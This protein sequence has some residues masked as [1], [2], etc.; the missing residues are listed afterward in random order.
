M[1]N[2]KHNT[3]IPKIAYF[4]WN[5][6]TPLSYLRYVTLLTFRK[7]HP[8]WNMT[9]CLSNANT[10]NKWLGLEQQ[11]F[12]FKIDSIDYT[13]KLFELNI[14]FMEYDK[15]T[16]KAPNYISDFFRWDILS[17]TGG[18]YFDLDQIFLKPFD[19][20]C[21]NDFVID[22]SA[23][24][25][26]GVVGC[27]K[28]CPAAK[29]ISDRIMYAYN[30]RFYNSVGPWYIRSLIHTPKDLK[31]FKLLEPYKTLFTE[32][33]I[34]YPIHP[35]NIDDIFK[36][37][38]SLP[39][40]SYTLHWF[41][42]HPVSQEYNKII[43]E[44]S[45]FEQSSTIVKFIEN[46]L[47]KKD[48]KVSFG[49]IVVNGEPWIEIV[50]KGLYKH[51]HS[52]CIAE[53]ATLNW[54]RGNNFKTPRSTDNTLSIIKDF[55]DPENKIRFVSSPEFYAEK[56]EQCNAWLD[57]VPKDTDYIWEV[58]TDEF[59]HDKDI[60]LIKKMLKTN[61]YTYVEFLT[62]NFFKGTDYIAQ[63]GIGWAYDTPFP[64]IFK[65]HNNCKWS[66]HRPPTILD[67]NGRDLKTIKPLLAKDN[68]VK[69]YHYSYVTDKQ[70][71]EK[72]QYYTKAF[73]RD[74]INQW[75]I[76][77]YKNWNNENRLEL[78]SRYSA[79]PS[80]KGATT[81]RF[82]GEHPK[83]IQQNVKLKN[84]SI[85]IRL[86]DFPTGIR[87]IMSDIEPLVEILKRF[88]RH[89]KYIKLGIVPKLLTP[90]YFNMIKDLEF[91]PCIHGYDHHYYEFS[92][93]L[94]NDPYNQHTIV[95][96]FNE[97][98]GD[99]TEKIQA[100]LLKGQTILEQYFQRAITTYIPP[101]NQLDETT[102]KILINL[103]LTP[104]IHSDFYG[105]VLELDFSKSYKI[106]TFHLTW[107]YDD[108]T[109]KQ[110]DKNQWLI[111][112]EKF[113]YYENMV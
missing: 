110:K 75:Y 58:D 62:L 5:N 69:I 52:I 109:W 27:S 100:K 113:K 1:F 15:H 67:E 93:K 30:P 99:S 56:L 104:L 98:E 106:A 95:K 103:G 29:Y 55:P 24:C 76:P 18:W 70:V 51:A 66:N 16:D 94:Q 81:K 107:E 13:N 35:D 26:V 12:L 101:C 34:F 102:N 85:I 73:G 87:P 72:M 32:R 33:E 28:E 65:Y 3:M 53:G 20:L 60:E 11:D 63:G 40:N 59:Y 82:N 78:E 68:P 8:D 38:I 42:G 7:L 97:F 83:V 64:R 80:C 84:D 43:T 77:F 48:I 89:F 19:D 96:G 90:E 46:T 61:N 25:F 39:E 22:G 91:E 86:D 111:N 2:R 49:I 47:C 9:L 57:L 44:K 88:C 21:N 92:P 37:V 45:I 23:S 41:G 4:Y 31:L 105:R 112:L 74:Y 17:E 14:N 79:H 54:Q 108:L 10:S 50:L 6:S 36:R 71:E